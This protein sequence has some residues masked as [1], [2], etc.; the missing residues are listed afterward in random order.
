MVKALKEHGAMRLPRRQFLKAMS[1]ACIA[2]AHPVAHMFGAEVGDGYV[3]PKGNIR[4]P[5]SDPMWQAVREFVTEPGPD[6]RH[7]SEAAFEAFRDIK[8]SVRIHWGLYSMQTWWD[9]SWPFLKLSPAEKAR[10][11]EQYKTWNPS[12]FD[13]DAWMRFFRENGMKMFTITPNHHEGFSMYDTKRR[14]RSRINWSHPGGPALEQCDLAYSIMETPFGRDV[15]REVVDAGRR[16]GLKVDLYFS[17]PNWYDAD[18]RPYVQHPCQVGSS[19]EL[20][21][22]IDYQQT[23]QRYGDHAL[24]VA[25][26]SPDEVRRMMA[27]HRQQLTELLTNYG[28]IDMVCLDM[29]LGKAVWPQMRDT[30]VALRKIQPEVM[31]RARGIGNYGD[32]YTPEHF[33]PGDKSAT[34]MPWFVI[35]PL[36]HGWSWG[37]PDDHFKGSVWVIR[38][39]TDIVAKGGNFMVGVGPDR[40]G[41]FHPTALQQLAEVGDWLKI[42]GEAIYGTRPRPGDLW[43]EGGD[44]VGAGSKTD[45]APAQEISGENPPIR[46][47]STKD[48]KTIYAFCLGWP[49]RKLLLRSIDGARVKMVSMLGFPKPLSISRSVNNALSIQIP[50]SMDDEA[51]RPCKTA[52]TFRIELIHA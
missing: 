8:Y 6:Y 51:N 29:W 30:I 14:I 45:D 40:D 24:L 1:A 25:D 43:K 47:S 17:H 10:Y 39:L 13:P 2:S 7:A 46:F 27:S 22:S 49:G 31:F 36:G 9:T 12:G 20:L 21:C 35:Y 28:K 3:P 32:Y 42:N 38:N 33:V 18:F 50:A 44:L 26:P 5:E 11:N 48:R 4:L 37:G 19:K 16:N 15:V 52:W 34:D 41:R 23:Q